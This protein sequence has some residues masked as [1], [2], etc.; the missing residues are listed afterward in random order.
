MKE[1][2]NG[3][4]VFNATPHVIRFWDPSWEWPVEVE[5]DVV[6]N[7]TPVETL[8]ET[9]GMVEFV[10]T[11]FVC[12]EDGH[13][14]ISRAFDEGADV[15]VGSIIAAQAYPGRVVAMTPAPGYERVAPS[16]KRMRPDKFTIF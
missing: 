6:V 11:D 3:V 1:L 15:V 16:E 2:P 13:D 12:D 10:R 14:T 8:V 4:R 9:W 7:A 5:P